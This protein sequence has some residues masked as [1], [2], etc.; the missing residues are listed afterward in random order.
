MLGREFLRGGIVDA[1]VVVVAEALGDVVAGRGVVDVGGVEDVV[2]VEDTVRIQV[3][4]GLVAQGPGQNR[5]T[6]V[7]RTR[8]G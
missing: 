8:I 6:A 7:G 2:A 3:D 1:V 4:E 5:R